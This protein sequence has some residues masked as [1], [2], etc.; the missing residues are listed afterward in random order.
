MGI[1][2]HE[3]AGQKLVE[4]HELTAQGVRSYDP[5]LRHTVT[6]ISSISV[7]D[8]PAE[9][10]Y[11]R[12][13]SLEDIYASK[14]YLEAV[15]L[16]LTGRFPNKRELS[17]VKEQAAKRSDIDERTRDG[18]TSIIRSFPKESDPI[19][20]VS[21]TMSYLSSVDPLPIRSRKEQVEASLKAIAYTPIVVG[22]ALRHIKGEELKFP[23]KKDLG[24]YNYSKAFLLTLN[25]GKQPSSEQVKMLDSIFTL[26][27]DAGLNPSTFAAQ[28]NVSSDTNI[29]RGLIAAS[30]SLSGS[31][32][33]G[34]STD[35]VKNFRTISEMPGKVDAKVK[36]FVS[37]KTAKGERIAG[38]GHV[39]F[40]SH[41]PRAKALERMADDMSPPPPYYDIAKALHKRISSPS[42]RS[43]KV[44]NPNVDFY[45]GILWKSLGVPEQGMTTAFFTARAPGVIAHIMEI[46]GERKLI[47][48]TEAYVGETGIHPDKLATPDTQ[49]PSREILPINTKLIA[50]P[51]GRARD[52]EL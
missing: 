42:A 37:D 18:I 39:I 5:E 46:Q 27:L 44:I 30:N 2:V 12:G 29:W 47:V 8:G 16:I 40:K 38:F 50:I 25:G 24:E 34:A 3:I 9:K 21:A 23:T 17:R 45:S 32:H 4:A 51:K 41:D 11:Y 1:K 33:G 7:L 28:Q 15:F 13:V 36:Q 22:L 35:V 14:E 31:L 19:A 20:I 52:V 48:P 49:K 26:H 10:I 6:N 43:S